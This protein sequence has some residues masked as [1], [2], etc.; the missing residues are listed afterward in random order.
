MA[1]EVIKEL[2][3]KVG[4]DFD[5]ATFEAADAAIG[6]LKKGLV[7]AGV[8][9]AAAGVALAGMIGKVAEAAGRVDDL[10]ASTGTNAQLLQG[11]AA[12]A[13]QSGVQMET[14]AK[15]FSF[16]AKSGVKDLPKYVYEVA[17][18]VKALTDKGQGP[19][20]AALAMQKFGA[21]A[22]GMT[23]WLKLGS[24][25]I[26]EMAQEANDL[27]YVMGPQMIADGDALGDNIDRLKMAF[28]GLA[29]TIAGPFLRPFAEAIDTLIQWMKANRQLIATRTRQYL[30]VVGA[31]FRLLGKILNPL[32]VT[33]GFLVRHLRLT[34]ILLGS[35]VLAALIANAS[36][37]AYATSWYVA[38]G[39]ASLVAAG[40]AA[41]A[42]A[43]AALPVV[44]I[45][46][47]I[48]LAV[49]VAE[50]LWVSFH[51]GKGVIRGLMETWASFYDRLLKDDP[52]DGAFMS[53]LKAILRAIADIPGTWDRV[54]SWVE[55]KS[56]ELRDY[57]VRLFHEMG[58]AI[59]Q[60]AK[61]GAKMALSYAVPGGALLGGRL[62]D[63]G[64]A[65][66]AAA[67]QTSAIASGPAGSPAARIGRG[68]FNATFNIAQRVGESS[69][70][71][72]RRARDLFDEWHATKNR[73][74]HGALGGESE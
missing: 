24:A 38:L 58:E 15:A 46:A 47:A 56:L 4:I 2:A 44:A 64:G 3:A 28:V 65:S 29:N 12:G 61:T 52:S 6:V 42:W 27:G 60:G 41:L 51:G 8:L 32:V 37:A 7:G 74:T 66:P 13:K 14:L 40:K 59:V 72:A 70:D 11:F 67:L 25:A 9:A 39:I 19:A 62:F 33:L 10:S 63:G 49:L 21:R 5:D 16:A 69:E 1:G 73:E 71:L 22:A 35:V 48:A 17:D 30:L 43:A 36:A 55:Q 53:G 54:T 20:A 68:T 50:D 57:L 45:A 34:A 23:G 26:R 18:Q 31:A